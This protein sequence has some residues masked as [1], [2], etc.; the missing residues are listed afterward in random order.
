MNYHL[1]DARCRSILPVNPHVDTFV[2]E[3]VNYHFTI[4]IFDTNTRM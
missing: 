1:L 4:A 2:A 3:L